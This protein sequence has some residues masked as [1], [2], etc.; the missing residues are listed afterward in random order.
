MGNEAAAAAAA[1]AAEHSEELIHYLAREVAPGITIHMQTMYMT[2]IVMILLILLFVFASKNAKLIPSGLQNVM[3]FFVEFIEGLVTGSLGAKGWKAIGSF[4]VS[5]F[6]FI[7]ISNELGML[8][9]VGVHWT[10]PTNDINTCFALSLTVAIGVYFVGVA[11]NG[12]GF[13]K[14]FVSPSPAFLPLHLLDELTKPL[15]M[16]LR[17]F[18]NI[19]AGEILLIILYKLAPWIVPEFWVMFSLFIGFLQAFIFTM[20]AI[21]S[22][23][24][25]YA[26]H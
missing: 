19:L 15:T 25:I 4:F 3:E 16:A 7:L 5:L 18:G 10:S 2:W 17:L 12:F 20:L 21:C 1:E 8:P 14:H 26:H 11:T 6:M 9:Q 22:Y 24:K 23:E 13:F